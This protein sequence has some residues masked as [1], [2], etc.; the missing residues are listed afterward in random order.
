MHCCAGAEAPNPA[1]AP[2]AADA[3][4]TYNWTAHWWPVAP[5]N[6]IDPA[7]P[8]PI[9]MLGHNYVVWYNKQQGSWQLMEDRCPHR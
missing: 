3:P 4:S 5:L 8:Y 9:T 1:A 7:K 2:A 6:A